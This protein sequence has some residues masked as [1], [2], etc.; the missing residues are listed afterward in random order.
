MTDPTNN[1]TQ[2]SFHDDRL[3]TMDELSDFTR[4]PK[5]TLY[6]MRSAGRGPVGFRIGKSLRFRRS[7]IDS[8]LDTLRDS[9]AA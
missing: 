4:T 8:W 9:E 6:S 1:Q 2:A 7:E 5:S 3:L